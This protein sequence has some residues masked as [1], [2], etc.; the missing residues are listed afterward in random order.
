MNITI[1]SPQGDFDIQM[2]ANS[3]IEDLKDAIVEKKGYDKEELIL[4][5]G[6]KKLVANDL[7]DCEGV[8]D[9]SIVTLTLREASARSY[10]NTQPWRQDQNTTIPGASSYGMKG[11]GMEASQRQQ[12]RPESPKMDPETVMKINKL[13][14]M[15]FDKRQAEVPIRKAKGV[16]QVAPSFLPLLEHKIEPDPMPEPSRSVFMLDL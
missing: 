10:M 1:Q 15:A 4:K 14:S 7:L 2:P 12:P 3:T 13:I 5:V 6:K 8:R 11:G 9:G 16:V